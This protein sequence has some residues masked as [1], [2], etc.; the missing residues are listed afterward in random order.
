MKAPVKPRGP[1]RAWAASL[2]TALGIP[3]LCWGLSFFI[4]T[5]F[6]KISPTIGLLFINSIVPTLW[7]TVLATPIHLA[8]YLVTGLPIF[9][10]QYEDPASIIWKA[11]V[12]IPVGTL[13]GGAVYLS[14]WV[15]MKPA[16]G[17]GDFYVTLIF[18]GY[19]LITAIAAYRQRPPYQPS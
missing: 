15:M 6:A 4:V 7:V 8:G 14:Y 10:T 5:L 18:A 3:I 11:T 9:M 13:L 16:F 12:A 2:P 19:G 1:F 17:I